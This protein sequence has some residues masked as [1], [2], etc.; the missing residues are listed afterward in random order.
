LFSVEGSGKSRFCYDL[1][2]EEDASSTWVIA[3][4]DTLG[5]RKRCEEVAMEALVSGH[6]VVIDR[7]NMSSQQRSTW[8]KLA[9]KHWPFANKNSIWCLHFDIPVEECIARCKNGKEGHQTVSC[10]EAEKVVMHQAREWEAPTLDEG[11]SAVVTFR[12]GDGDFYRNTVKN[13]GKVLEA[14]RN[15]DEVLLG[16]T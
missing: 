8:V 1:F 5:S 16:V 14:E 6:R 9:Q 13:L 10:E 2:E 15:I 7:C 3:S 12:T 4:Q 11:F